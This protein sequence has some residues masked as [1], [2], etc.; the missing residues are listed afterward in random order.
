MKAYKPVLVTIEEESFLE[1]TNPKDKGR[2]SAVK[3]ICRFATFYTVSVALLCVACVMLMYCSALDPKDRLQDWNHTGPLVSMDDLE[4]LGAVGET[5]RCYLLL[6][7]PLG[8]AQRQTASNYTWTKRLAHGKYLLVC[9]LASADWM[10]AAADSIR[11][12]MPD[13]LN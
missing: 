3:M 6:L 12:Q 1:P 9:A 11:L 13:G 5:S 4:T 8:W 10:G 7:Q 2:T